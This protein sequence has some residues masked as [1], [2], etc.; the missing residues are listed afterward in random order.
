M[1]LKP[2][3]SGQPT[4]LLDGAKVDYIREYTLG[5]GTQ[6]QGRTNGIAIEA[7]KPGEI[8]VAT[9][10]NTALTSGNAVVAGTLTLKR[11]LYVV[12]YKGAFTYATGMPSSI[13][14]I[15]VS[16]STNTSSDFVSTV[17]DT[18]NDNL[19]YERHVGFAIRYLNISVDDTPVNAI[20]SATFTGGS[21]IVSRGDRSSFFAIRIA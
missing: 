19:A 13:Q 21:D 1:S 15:T 17:T 4:E 6:L 2:G 11:G 9:M 14:Y 18:S 20:M 10:A 7:G 16:I 5:N 3:I 12:Y 8:R